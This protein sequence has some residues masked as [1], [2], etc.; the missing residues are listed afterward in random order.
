MASVMEPGGTI[1]QEAPYPVRLEVVYS[2]K[3]SR[4]STFFRGFLIIPHLVVLIFI[5]IAQG[6]VAFISWWVILFTGKYPK[7]M[8]NFVADT[9]RWQARLNAYSMYLTDKYPP[10]NG[11]P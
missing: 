7:G 2:E 11:Q 6:L 1:E 8:F 9:S 5:G 3:H 10:F 4:L